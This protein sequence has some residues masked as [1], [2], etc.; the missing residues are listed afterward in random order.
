MKNEEVH[1]VLL[2]QSNQIDMIAGELKWILEE[3]KK[4]NVQPGTSLGDEMTQKFFSLFKDY[5]QVRNKTLELEK[6]VRTVVFPDPTMAT[7]YLAT[8]NL[9]TR[10]VTQG[11]FEQF[12]SVAETGK[13]PDENL[14]S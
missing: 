12:R 2:E 3:C 7:I 10:K 14:S 11:I 6:E 1:D 9:L 8:A 5:K 4:H 13:L